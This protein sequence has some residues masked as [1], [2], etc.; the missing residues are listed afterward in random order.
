MSGRDGPPV[1]DV[2]CL[3]YHIPEEGLRGRVRIMS[4]PSNTPDAGPV[5]IHV[6]C[7]IE[8][9][10]SRATDLPLFTIPAGQL[11]SHKS[12]TEETQEEEGYDETEDNP[13]ELLDQEYYACTNEKI[14]TPS[15]HPQTC[16]WDRRIS[17]PCFYRRGH[18]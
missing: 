15:L 1:S 8:H 3:R 9:L 7:C 12:I 11:S 13:R 17:F 6:F 18:I 5:N 4:A 16:T 14:P 2:S 10:L